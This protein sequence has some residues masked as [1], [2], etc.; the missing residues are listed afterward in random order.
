MSPYLV[1]ILKIASI[2][3]NSGIIENIMEVIGKNQ[4]IRILIPAI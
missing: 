4:E 2:N 3:D 1:D